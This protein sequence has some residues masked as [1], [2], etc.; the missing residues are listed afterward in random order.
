MEESESFGQ[1]KY[2]SEKLALV[3]G[4]ISTPPGTPL[5]LGKN[6]RVCEDCHEFSAIFAKSFGM[7][8]YHS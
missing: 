6:L 8:F 2:H 1:H 7:F 4:L 3:Y 5:V